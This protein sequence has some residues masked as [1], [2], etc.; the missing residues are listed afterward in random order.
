MNITIIYGATRPGNYGQFVAAAINNITAK[1][2][3]NIN[4][5]VISPKNF[6]IPYDGAKIKEY[7]Q[8]VEHTDAF[9]V[10]VSEYNHGY[11]G[12]LKS[13]MD[14]EFE[15][16]FGK[17]V[18]VTVLSDGPFGGARGVEAFVNVL[19]AYKMFVLGNDILI[20]NVDKKFSKEGVLLDSTLP[21]YIIKSVTELILLAKKPNQG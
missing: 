4:L 5:K 3:S 2:F 9:I 18:L 12:M 13:L 14:L 6:T 19:K 15:N 11:P 17:P 1:N 10:V 21:D 7:T 20:N 8:L 16:Y